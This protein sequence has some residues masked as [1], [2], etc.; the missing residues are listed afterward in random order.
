MKVTSPRDIAR[1]LHDR[2]LSPLKRFGQNFLCDENVV[3]KIAA[4]AAP[5]GSFVLEIGTGLG[6]LTR[7]LA[8]RAARVVSVEIDR[9]LLDTHVQT[10]AGIGNV[11]VLEGDILATDLGAV[12]REYFGGRPFYVCGNLPYYITSRI[13]P[14]VLESEA[15]VRGLT[16]MVQKEV[17]ARLSANAGDTEYGALTASCRY[18]ADA[19]L[20]FTVSRNCFYPAPDVDSAIL[21]FDLTRPPLP[22]PRDAYVRTVRASFAMRRKT[23]YNNLKHI[24]GAKQVREALEAAGIP[25]ETRAQDISPKR[26]CRLAELL[27]SKG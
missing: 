12:C 14:H 5:A 26:F 18:Y 16:V 13:L 20:L 11:T 24:A 25:P 22:V 4:A 19:G 23:I 7:E 21:R 9:G 1:I 3:G 27:F 8:A 15:P 17:A 2:G 10:L 6:A